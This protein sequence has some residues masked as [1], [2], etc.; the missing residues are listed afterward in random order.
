MRENLF[1]VHFVCVGYYTLSV[2]AF[3]L[4]WFFV[5]CFFVFWGLGVCETNKTTNLGVLNMRLFA[6]YFSHIQV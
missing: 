1:V 4:F 2:F 5:F 6:R 3:S